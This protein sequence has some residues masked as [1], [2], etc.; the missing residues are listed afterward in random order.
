MPRTRSP[1]IKISVSE[2][3]G[4]LLGESYAPKEIAE[5]NR[6]IHHKLGLTED[7]EYSIVL[8]GLESYGDQK[9][10]EDKPIPPQASKPLC[11]VF[12]PDAVRNGIVYELKVLRRY[13]DKEK[14][15]LWGFLQIQLELYA[16]GLERGKLLLYKLDDGVVEELDVEANPLIAEEVL[17]FYHDILAARSRLLERLLDES[18]IVKH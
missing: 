5:E 6:L 4:H 11:L 13:S 10:M 18:G 15:L 1:V 7:Q 3:L 12:R 14:L 9:P 17:A 16:L 8:G 2:L